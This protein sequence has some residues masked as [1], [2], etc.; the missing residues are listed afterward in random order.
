MAEFLFQSVALIG[1]RISD[2]GLKRSDV[3]LIVP[4]SK[5][6]ALRPPRRTESKVLNDERM[7][8]LLLTFLVGPIVGA[9]LRLKDEL[10]A[11]ARMF[12]NGLAEAFEC[13]EPDGGD[14]LPHVAA[15]ILPCIIVADEAE[16]R[17]GGIAFDRQFWILG[18]I[19]NGGDSKAIHDYSF[20]WCC[21]AKKED[22]RSRAISL[23]APSE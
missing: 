9:D 6:F 7:V 10:I 4:S 19:S 17:I 18:E 2:F 12:G 5:L 21:A 16:T 14:G 3:P 11:L 8:V 13:H 15:L 22:L 23:R 1:M 20:D